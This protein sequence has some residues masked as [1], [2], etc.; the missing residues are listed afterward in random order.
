MFPLGNIRRLVPAAEIVQTLLQ[1]LI[2]RRKDLQQLACQIL[3]ERVLASLNLKEDRILDDKAGL[4][5]A[6]LESHKFIIPQ[7]LRNCVAKHK[8]T[9]YHG[10]ASIDV[11]TAEM[12]YRCGFHDVDYP[13]TSGT[14]PVM[15]S[16][17]FELLFWFVDKGANLLRPRCPQG[18][19]AFS[20][21]LD[22]MWRSFWSR[23]NSI[24]PELALCAR[25][26]FSCGL[27]NRD[28]CNCA[29]SLGGCTAISFLLRYSNW[30]IKWLEESHG[31]DECPHF[32]FLKPIFEDDE[33]SFS[34][35]VPG[36]IRSLT[37][38][39]LELSHTCCRDPVERSNHFFRPEEV[40]EIQE[41]EREVIEDLKDLVEEFLFKW[42][43]LG[44]PIF[45]FMKGYWRDRMNEYLKVKS[46][47]DEEELK[48]IADL[49]VI[50]NVE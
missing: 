8:P 18:L 22:Y 39:K 44:I 14:T 41:E 10:I 5:C 23:Q 7:P 45:D 1:N 47:P 38:N 43:E 9:V 19:P 11:E 12:F 3:P 33:D 24:P 49:G 15:E 37:F 4:V 6:A 28:K 25:E 48:R 40:I 50:L 29:C 46:Q 20:C 35:F 27:Q 34:Q 31:L 21:A 42:D 36:I 2:A 30:W 13:D 16:F 32:Q 17:N 26:P